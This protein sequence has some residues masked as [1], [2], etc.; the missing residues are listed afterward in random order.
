MVHLILNDEHLSGVLV[1]GFERC[2]HRLFISTADVKNVHIPGFSPTARETNKASS[3]VE[4]F[5]SLSARGVQINLLHSGVPSGPL[6]AELK[7]GIPSNLTMRRCPRVHAKAVVVD[8]R[9]MYL[10]SANLTGAGLGAKS[11][12]RRNFEAGIWTN[13]LSMIDPVVDMLDDVFNGGQ[14]ESC[15]RKRYCPVPLEE[16]EL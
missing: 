8:G 5:E 1:E 3:I 4:V 15:G 9:W 6:L 10:G 2:R 7:R 13:E 12:R 11:V 14:C 16:P